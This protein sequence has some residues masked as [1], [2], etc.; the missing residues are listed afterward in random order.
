LIY[1]DT[2][3]VHELYS[4]IHIHRNIFILKQAV[5]NCITGIS[6]IYFLK[7]TRTLF[8]LEDILNTNKGFN[9]LNQIEITQIT[10]VTK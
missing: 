3:K 5:K 1:Q 10:F 2:D 8:Q 4:Y 7:T 9:T 6:E